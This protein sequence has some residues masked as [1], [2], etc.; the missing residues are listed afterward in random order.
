MNGTALQKLPSKKREKHLAFIRSLSCVI[1]A[2]PCEPCH[3]RFSDA[4]YGTHNTMSKKPDDMFTLPLCRWHHREQH[5]GSEVEYWEKVG[6]DPHAMALALY[7][8]S[9]DIERGDRIV[10]AW[11]N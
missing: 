7:R 2:C 8:I 9:G 4:R 1:C 5:S 3:V 11:R 10:A 6:I